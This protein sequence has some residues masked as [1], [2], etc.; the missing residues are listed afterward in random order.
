MC[1]GGD[2]TRGNGTGG[3]IIYGDKLEDENFT[4]KHEG[5][6]KIYIREGAIKKAHIYEKFKQ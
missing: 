5:P 2:F 6:G 3:K 4:M 1:Q